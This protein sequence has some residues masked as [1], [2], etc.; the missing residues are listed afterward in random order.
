MP[1]EVRADTGAVVVRIVATEGTSVSA[2][3]DL[4]ILESMKVE[5]PVT[6]EV[7]GIVTAVMVDEGT[8]VSE[9]DILASID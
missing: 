3:D 8:K 2:G 7:G 1:H 9:G 6:A 4:I 5:I